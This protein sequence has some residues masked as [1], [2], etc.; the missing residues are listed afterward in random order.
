L[1]KALMKIGIF[2]EM[3]PSPVGSRGFTLIELALVA[4][5]L[6]VLLVSAVPHVRRG[7]A[8]MQ[9]ERTAFQVA[10]MLRTARAVAISEGCAVDWVVGRDHNAQRVSL[11]LD[12]STCAGKTIPTRMARTMVVP[13]PITVNPIDRVRFSPDGT[14]QSTTIVVTDDTIPRYHITVDGS[15]SL[16]QTRAGAPP[17]AP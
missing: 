13:P 7:A 10:Q 14:S 6:A 15:T 5:T 9:T 16:V 17:T 11:E 8:N 1:P 4:V 12:D 2:S 3:S